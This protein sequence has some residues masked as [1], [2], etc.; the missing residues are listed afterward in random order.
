MCELLLVSYTI[1]RVKI[2]TIKI[3]LLSV[4]YTINRV[5]IMYQCLLSSVQEITVH[6]GTQ[7]SYINNTEIHGL[8]Q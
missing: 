3:V 7:D 6:V 8:Q 2:I 1:N 4:S 5:K